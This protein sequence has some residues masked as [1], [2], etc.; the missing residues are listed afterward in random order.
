VLSKNTQLALG[1]CGSTSAQSLKVRS[2]FLGQ[3]VWLTS[4]IPGTQAAE[5]RKI[6][7]QGQPMQKVINNPP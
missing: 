7:I 5:I 6:V 4:V 3:A 2:S 1:I